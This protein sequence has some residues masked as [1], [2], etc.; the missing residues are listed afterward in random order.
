ML[1]GVRALNKAAG[2]RLADCLRNF[3]VELDRVPTRTPGMTLSIKQLP[4]VS[5]PPLALICWLGEA[6]SDSNYLATAGKQQERP[7]IR[8]KRG[9]DDCGK[10]KLRSSE[11]IYNR[12]KWDPCLDKET[13]LIG[14]LDRF[15]GEQEML[16]ENWRRNPLDIIPWHRVIY[17]KLGGQVV[18]DK[19]T[20]LDR[21]SA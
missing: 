19:R 4:V 18:W 6:R 15:K 10:N 14:Y 3:E 11:V 21:L 2:P 16:F 12:I 9:E 13:C 8:D 17:F 20:R 1:A 5:L 7:E